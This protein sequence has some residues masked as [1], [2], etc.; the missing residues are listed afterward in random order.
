MR[1][2]EKR[3]SWLIFLQRED[4]GTTFTDSSS[5]SILSKAILLRTV[6]PNTDVFLQRLQ[7]R[8]KSRS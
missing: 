5:C 8:E 7:L 4:L 3:V 6:P 2:A 1:T